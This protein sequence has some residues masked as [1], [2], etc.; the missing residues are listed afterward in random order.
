MEKG[1]FRKG[2]GM[3]NVLFMAIWCLF[4]S[5]IAYADEVDDLLEKELLEMKVQL[6]AV[7]D[8]SQTL[9]SY[10]EKLE[11]SLSA[12]NMALGRTESMK[13]TPA[14]KNNLEIRSD[15]SLENTKN[16]IEGALGQTHNSYLASVNEYN[17]NMRSG[18]YYSDKNADRVSVERIKYRVSAIE[19]IESIRHMHYIGATNVVN[20]SCVYRKYR[21][22][23]M[24]GACKFKE[25]YTNDRVMETIDSSSKSIELTLNKIL[26]DKAMFR[27]FLQGVITVF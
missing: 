12:L 18:M 7:E 11:K 8:Y 16:L 26:D 27:D 17:K 19:Y 13:C 20:L 23:V 3:R 4:F 5:P 1:D 24:S 22:C 6:S 2:G 9:S 10:A 15:L 14:E 25:K 21:G